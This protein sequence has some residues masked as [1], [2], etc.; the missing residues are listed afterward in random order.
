MKMQTVKFFQMLAS[1]MYIYG[2]DYEIDTDEFIEYL[3]TKFELDKPN[4]E[5]EP[6]DV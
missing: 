4:K 6:T 1:T 5:P 2:A 3:R